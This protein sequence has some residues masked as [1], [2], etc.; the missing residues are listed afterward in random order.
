MEEQK[1]VEL[2]AAKNETPK[3]VF[4]AAKQ[5]FNWAIG[6]ELTEE[7]F[8]GCIAATVSHKIKA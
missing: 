7:E 2:W 5:K 8:D 1:T 3:W 6:A 4:A